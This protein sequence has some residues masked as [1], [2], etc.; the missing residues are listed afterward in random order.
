VQGAP[1]GRVRR[2]PYSAAG[3]GEPGTNLG[4][5]VP[6]A[7]M[8]R[9][10]EVSKRYGERV[11]VDRISL[12]VARGEVLA[13]VGGS[14]SGKTTTLKLIN[15]LV[16]PSSGSIAVSGTDTREIAPHELRRTIGYVLQ[17]IGLFPHMT[18][19]ENIGLTPKL[20]GWA[21]EAI[22]RRTTELSS[23]VELD[24]DRVDTRF[25]HELSGGQQQRVGIARALAADP[26]VMLLDEPFGSLDAITRR[27]LQRL[28]A[29]IHVRRQLTAIFVTHDID[30]AL[31]LGTRVAVLRAGRLL[32]VG[33]PSELRDAPA[34]DYVRALLAGD[35]RLLDAAEGR[36]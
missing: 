28:F 13:L 35:D 9:L 33:T 16:E 18:V 29:E 15:R 12:Q 25:P 23:L 20:L 2:A 31:R 32:Q 4:H 3:C 30:E 7:Q 5:E 21:P 10:D 6:D 26:S 17:G 8:I 1:S 19:A 11:A 36:S 14:G 24:K 27:R 34:D 22:A